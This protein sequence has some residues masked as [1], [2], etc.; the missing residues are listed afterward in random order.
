MKPCRICGKFLGC[1]CVSREK[2]EKAE[3]ERDKVQAEL[4]GYIDHSMGLEWAI[5]A[6]TEALET[7]KILDIEPADGSGW[8]RGKPSLEDVMRVIASQAL[9]NTDDQA[10][11]I[12][13]VVEAAI[14][15]RA[16][17]KSGNLIAT[18]QAG[19]A[20]DRAIKAYEG[21]E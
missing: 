20:L 8:G 16:K 15:Y 9:A 13:A 6:L 2:Y 21:S 1:D 11:K 4:T 19:D 17:L 5:A 14:D 3:A 7:I 12:T 10:A 18:Q